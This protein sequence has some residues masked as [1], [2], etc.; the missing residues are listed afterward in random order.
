SGTQ[1]NPAWLSQGPDI[2]AIDNAQV[3]NI[4]NC[5]TSCGTG[6]FPLVGKVVFANPSGSDSNPGT[7]ALPVATLDKVRTLIQGTSGSLGL[8]S[9]DAFYSTSNVLFGSADSGTSSLPMTYRGVAGSTVFSGGQTVTGW[10]NC[11]RVTHC[12]NIPLAAMS[13]SG[14]GTPQ[15]ITLS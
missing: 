4:Y 9:G 11:D 13:C 1:E 3:L 2:L 15:F 5:L 10:A 8:F 6:P 12:V 14:C 7:A